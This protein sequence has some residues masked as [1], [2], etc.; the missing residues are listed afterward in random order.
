[1]ECLV[2]LTDLE[3]RRAGLSASAELL[4]LCGVRWCHSRPP[5]SGPHFLVN[6]LSVWGRI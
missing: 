1:M 2:T 4:V 6:F 3:T 5:N